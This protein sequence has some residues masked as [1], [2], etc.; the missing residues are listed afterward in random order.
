MR[1]SQ[2]LSAAA[3]A[4]MF[5]LLG[6]ATFANE[7]TKKPPAN[8]VGAG[9][10]KTT[11]TTNNGTTGGTFTPEQMAA[12]NR[13]SGYFNNL[14]TLAGR[15]VQTD[16]DGTKSR[17]KFYV[18]RPGM[19][20]F[21]YGRPSVKVV[22]SDGRFLAIEDRDAGTEETYEVSDTPFRMLLRADVNLVRDAIVLQVDETDSQISLVLRD[23]DPD[24]GAAI[25]VV[26]TTK[27]ELVL[28]GWITRD[29]Q[30]LETTVEATDVVHGK[31]VDPKLFQREKLFL[32]S[33]QQ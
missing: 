7:P 29:A 28:R 2:T 20:R 23:K 10:G 9:W 24:I 32:K 3:A 33:V 4:A 26:M 12:V 5:G 30:G 11:I 13:V 25:K 6:S 19:F 14:Q 15:F 22:V 31:D 27:P 8:P 21:E 18:K 16:P 1:L 17:G